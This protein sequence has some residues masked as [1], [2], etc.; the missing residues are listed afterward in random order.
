[1]RYVIFAR[2]NCG[3]FSK[4]C[5][6]PLA[7]QVNKNIFVKGKKRRIASENIKVRISIPFVL[8]HT[9]Y[10]VY[11]L[12]NLGFSNI[13]YIIRVMNLLR[14][15]GFLIKLGQRV[16]ILMSDEI[17]SVPSGTLLQ[18]KMQSFER[19]A[20][21]WLLTLQYMRKLAETLKMTRR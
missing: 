7:K 15:K 18:K 8:V 14:L 16:R 5:N 19:A 13:Y 17:P 6:S 20:L 10:T 4:Y 12:L 1:M 9:I 11:S 2:L 3:D 21:N